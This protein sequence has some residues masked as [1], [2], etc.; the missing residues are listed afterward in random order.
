MTFNGV[1]G[2]LAF[3][4]TEQGPPIDQRLSL[5]LMQCLGI[6]GK[7]ISKKYLGVIRYKIN[8]LAN[9]VHDLTFFEI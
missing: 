9:S 1:V 4:V 5:K 6:L 7:I 2:C 8:Q 3:L